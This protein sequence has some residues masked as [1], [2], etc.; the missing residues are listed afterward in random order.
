MCRDILNENGVIIASIPN[1]MHISV[2]EALIDGR[3]PYADTGLLDRTHIHFFTFYE[4]M[5]MFNEAGYE[6]ENINV[7]EFPLTERQKE[8]EKVLLGL[9]DKTEALMY[10]AFQYIVKA[11]R[12]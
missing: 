6:M 4:I 8:I 12:Q 1:V 9:S 5:Y 2:M 7:S 3:F 10:E 11:R